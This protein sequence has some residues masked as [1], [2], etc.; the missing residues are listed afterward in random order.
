VRVVSVN[1]GQPATLEWGGRALWTAIVKRPVEGSVAVHQLGIEGDAQ[2]DRRVH[3]GPEQAVYAYAAEDLAWWSAQLGRELEP[4]VFGENLTLSGVDVTH[5]RQ[6]ERWAIGSTLLEVTKPRLPCVKL[7]TRMHDAL[8][9]R[10]F[11]D[12]GRPGAY[13]RVVR[14]GRV[15]AGDEVALDG[16]GDGPSVG[17]TARLI[18]TS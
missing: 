3:G 14:E 2:A 4:G 13:L 17:E 8:F 1:V 10:R 15:R 18:L 7:A 9:V 5:A 12:A 6:G 16:P 11:G